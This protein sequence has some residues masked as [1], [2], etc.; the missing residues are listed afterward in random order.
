L[1]SNALAPPIVGASIKVFEI[2]ENKLLLFKGELKK[3]IVM[4][5]TLLEFFKN[6]FIFILLFF[7]MLFILF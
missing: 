4:R 2:M 7:I 5:F 6:Y 3:G 1:F